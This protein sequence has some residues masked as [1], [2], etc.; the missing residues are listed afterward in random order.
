MVILGVREH[1]KQLVFD[2]ERRLSPGFDFVRLGKRQANLAESSEWAWRH[3]WGQIP[4]SS[5]S[6]IGGA[7]HRMLRWNV[8]PMR[9]KD[10][11]ET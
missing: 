4:I 3:G 11:I 7:F 1:G 5:F 9:R 10:E 8:S 6:R 2:A